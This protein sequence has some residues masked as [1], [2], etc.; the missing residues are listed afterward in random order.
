MKVA[1]PAWAGLVS[2]VFDFAHFLVLVELD[3]GE[4]VSRSEFPLD[5]NPSV[6]RAGILSRLGVDVLICG[7]ISRPLATAVEGYGIEIISFVS[8][9]V[10][11]VL[12]AYLTG[13]LA[14]ARFLLP[15]GPASGGRLWKAA[16]LSEMPRR[17]IRGT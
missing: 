11:E 7:A 3:S 13:Q 8:G 17:Q 15:G 5:E 12:D 9:I 2:T 16:N 1:I 14:E 6:L 4:E 10:D